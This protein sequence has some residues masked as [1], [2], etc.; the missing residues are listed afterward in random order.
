MKCKLTMKEHGPIFGS[1]SSFLQFS[2]SCFIILVW[3]FPQ[4]LCTHAHT[5]A[6]WYLQKIAFWILAPQQVSQE[7]QLAVRWE[8]SSGKTEHS[9]LAVLPGQGTVLKKLIMIKSY[10]H[11]KL[12]PSIGV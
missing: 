2:K 10:E 12:Y 9:I 4:K 3:L 11:L 7:V 1:N 5:H 6:K 8:G